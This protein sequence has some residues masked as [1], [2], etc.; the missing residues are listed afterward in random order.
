VR[1]FLD[2]VRK[3][4]ATAFCYV[5]ECCRYLMNHPE[6]PDDHDNPLVKIIGVG[7]RP[8]I[9]KQFKRRFGVKRVYEIYSAAES[10]LLFVNLLN[11]DCTVG[12]CFTPYAIV[13][14]DLETGEPLR[15]QRGFMQRVGPGESGLVLSKITRLSPFSGYTSKKATEDKLIRDGFKKGDLWFNTGDLLRDQGYW[16]AQFIDRLGDTFRWKGENVS[17]TEVEKVAN[18]F[19][20]VSESAVY[21]VVMPGSDGRAGMAS[22]IANT[23]IED[24]DFN[25]LARL[26]S[27]SL[28]H[29]AQPKF[30]RIK[31]GFET[32]AT[33]K[34]KKSALKQ[35][36]F[37]PDKISD[38]LFVLLPGE[39]EY[40]P[41]TEEIHKEINAG[42][43][44]F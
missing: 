13:K 34:I 2:D 3:Y 21:G 29:Y 32:T 37:D 20:Q 6:Q 42:R 35:E 19:P 26:F 10:N 15:D 8:D 28:P 4:D 40:R 17:T 24:F 12:M 43:Y 9:W 16:Q 18:T 14:Y 7:L 27:N 23:E 44:K 31:A 30:V 22:L 36:G 39:S 38:P 33:H 25:G 1:H 41:L 5:G 11:L